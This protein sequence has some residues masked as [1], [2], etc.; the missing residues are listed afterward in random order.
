M[1]NLLQ[2]IALT[3]ETLKSALSPG[4]LGMRSGDPEKQQAEIAENVTKL[5]GVTGEIKKL[6]NDLYKAEVYDRYRELLA[7]SLKNAVRKALTYTT[8][9]ADVTDQW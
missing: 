3:E 4:E 8:A 9:L 7:K 5:V 6:A 2:A 1:K